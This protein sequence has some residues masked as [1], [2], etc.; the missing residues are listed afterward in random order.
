MLVVR[1]RIPFLEQFDRDVDVFSGP[2]SVS[3]NL[4]NCTAVSHCMAQTPRAF[5]FVISCTDRMIE[6][7]AASR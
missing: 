2:P 7:T 3:Y 6:L 5:T 1:S 4:S